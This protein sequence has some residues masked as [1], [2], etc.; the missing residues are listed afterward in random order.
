MIHDGRH[1]LLVDVDGRDKPGHD[2]MFCGAG[3]VLQYTFIRS[4]ECHLL[5]IAGESPDNAGDNILNNMV[6]PGKSGLN[7]PES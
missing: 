5:D 6:L 1:T 2:E 7:P 4:I 3:S